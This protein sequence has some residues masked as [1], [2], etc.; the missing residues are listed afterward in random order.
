MNRSKYRSE[1][2]IVV[3]R[4]AKVTICDEVMLVNLGHSV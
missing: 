2:W 1:H 4:I 3:E